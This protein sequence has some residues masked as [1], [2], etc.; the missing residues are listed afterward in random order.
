MVINANET[1][2]PL[3]AKD[4]KSD[5]H[6]DWCPGCGDFGIVNVIQQTF[7]ELKLD[8]D[9]VLLYS[10]VGCSS[11]TPH[12]VRTYGV[13]TLHG[14]SLPF[15]VGSKLANHDLN[16]VVVGGDGDGYGI[17]A[18]HFLNTGRRN[19]NMTYIV[20]DNGVYGLTKGQA[21]PTLKLGQQTKSLA[22]PNPNDG[23]NPL[24]VAI[25]AGYTFVARS[26]AF[27]AKHL[28]ETLKRAMMHNGMSIVD[29]LQP[30][31]TYNNLTTK[32][33]YAEEVQVDGVPM[34]RVYDVEA[35]GYNGKVLDPT[36][37]DAMMETKIKAL[38]RVQQRE[39]RIPLG[40]F[41]QVEV[42]TYYERA[43]Q[44]MPALKECT[45]YQRKIME[46]DGTPV[47]DLKDSYAA[48]RTDTY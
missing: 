25:S 23:I 43:Q 16:V 45:T 17:G 48:F 30:C 8:P 7:A 18:G 6:P 12:F 24:A 31:P 5:V 11:K 40:V 22:M 4:Y 38:A 39:A 15:A 3:A 33:W 41:Y 21:S 13:H 27:N 42:P 10:G 9:N 28:K 36:N 32:E 19:V 14:R 26:Y 46:K 44:V 34:P 2:K 47:V 1:T 29:V 35:E 37:E 20:Y